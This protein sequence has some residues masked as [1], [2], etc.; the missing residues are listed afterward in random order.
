MYALHLEHSLAGKL[1]E[2]GSQPELNHVFIGPFFFGVQEHKARVLEHGVL[3]HGV[4]VFFPCVLE[5][6]Y[7]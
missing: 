6:G 4:L 3:E 7:F 5:H 1:L 2:V